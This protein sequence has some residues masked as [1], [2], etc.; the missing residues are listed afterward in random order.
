LSLPHSS[1]RLFIFAYPR[2]SAPAPTTSFLFWERPPLL[3]SPR[4]P[5][6]LQLGFM[7]SRTWSVEGVGAAARGVSRFDRV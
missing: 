1:L 3:F 5:Q 7:P 2:L 4:S 6:R